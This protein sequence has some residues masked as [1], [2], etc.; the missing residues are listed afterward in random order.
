[1]RFYTHAS[2][3]KAEDLYNKESF[4]DND[5]FLRSALFNEE[6]SG[7][8]TF[9]HGQVDDIDSR[10]WGNLLLCRNRRLGELLGILPLDNIF[11]TGPPQLE[12]DRYYSS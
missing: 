1:M 9:Y 2:P 3:A 6:L 8:M 5:N 10:A 4:F 12:V 11:T 7:R